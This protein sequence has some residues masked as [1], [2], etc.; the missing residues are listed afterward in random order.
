M[1]RI[2]LALS[3]LTLHQGLCAKRIAVITASYQNKDYYRWSLDSLFAQDHDDWYCLYTD[4]RSADATGDFVE[5]YIQEKGFQDKVILVKNT[6][7]K[8]AM[9]NQYN[10]IHSCAATDVCVIL[11]GDDAL[12][13][14]GVLS[15]I[16]DT[17]EKEDVWLTFGQFQ[18]WPGGGRGFC[19]PMPDSIIQTNA[20]R[21]YQDIPSHLRTFYAG[22]FQRIKKEDLMYNGAFLQMCAD[23]AAMIPMIEMANKHHKFIGQILLLYNARN[24]INDHKVSKQLQRTLD[25]HIRSLRPYAP[26][27]ALFQS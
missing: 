14:P 17:Y 27:E 23:M 20:F 22:L 26:L 18:E 5:H 3:L 8:G 21:Q 9:E 12:A 15:F 25:I 10:M 7:R 2:L 24:P 13:H 6:V 16:S 4:D 1:K 11:D 19:H